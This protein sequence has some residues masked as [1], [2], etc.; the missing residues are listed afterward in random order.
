MNSRDTIPSKFA[1][2]KTF[3]LPTPNVAVVGDYRSL[4]L[5]LLSLLVALFRTNVLN[6]PSWLHRGGKDGLPSTRCPTFFFF[7]ASLVRLYQFVFSTFS[8]SSSR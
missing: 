5:F 2:S 7:V 3:L 4:V 6:L 1:G 8:F